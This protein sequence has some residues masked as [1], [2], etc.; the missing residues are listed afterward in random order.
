MAE[1]RTRRTEAGMAGII[2]DGRVGTSVCA[3]RI[4]SYLTRAAAAAVLLLASGCSG[5]FVY[6]GSTGNGGG[7]NSTGDYVYVANASTANIAGFSVGTGT[8]T[9]VPNSPYALAASAAPTAIVVNPAN[10]V[11]YVAAGTSIYAYGIQSNGVLN[12]L[13]GGLPVA[14]ATV[15]SMDI[16]PDGN[17]LIA[18]DQSTAN[19]SVVIDQ[20]RINTNNGGLTSQG[21]L[22]LT[23]SGTA[24]PHAIKVSPDAQLV[25]GALG[26]AGELV[27]RF[28]TGAGT[29]STPSQFAPPANTSDDA[30]AVDSNH[31]Y[32]FIGRSG[33]TGHGLAV[34]LINGGALSSAP[35]SPFVAGN[36]PAAEK[37]V[38]LN[39]AGT[40][41]YVA[42]FNDGTISGFSIGTGGALTALSGSP[43][44]SGLNVTSLAIDNGGNYLLA[45]ASG[46]SPDL[47]LYSFD[48]ATAGKLNLAASSATGAPPTVAIALA[49]TH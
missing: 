45:A 26:T 21:V 48:S 31:N 40:S 22:T 34:D 43:Y 38:V 8:L 35:G 13:N 30:I 20:Y 39:K 11:L 10:T 32:L 42:N 41:V 28:D 23:V 14:S 33:S 15:A 12:A 2:E 37:S 36:Q 6:P 3:G 29:L 17:W 16:S 4:V 18:L 44:N 19:T 49:A 9:P 47:S 1:E 5:F 25:F 24:V 27:F 46:G 7:G